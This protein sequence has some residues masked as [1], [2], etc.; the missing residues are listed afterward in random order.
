M[1]ESEATHFG[2]KKLAL[3]NWRDPDVPRNFPGLTEEVWVRAIMGAQLIPAVPENVVRLFEVAR[4]SI[5]YGWLFY[6]LLTL[7]S[8]Q[9]HRVQETAVRERCKLAGIPLKQTRNGREV[10][11]SFKNL[12]DELGAHGIIPNDEM[13]PW[14]AVRNLRNWSSHPERQKIL[15]PGHAISAIDVTARQINQLFS[16]NPD[17]FSRLGLRV[18]RATGLGSPPRELPTVVG[19]DVGAENNGFHLV[20]MHGAQVVGAIKTLDPGEAR[21]WCI[22][23]GSKYVVVDAPCGWRLGEARNCRECEELL[24]TMGY[25]SYPTPRRDLA[26]SNPNYSWM[27]NGER[28]YTALQIDYPLFRGT[29]PEG[30]MCFETYP[31]VASCGLAGRK[32]KADNK[33][34]DRRDIIRAAGIDDRPLRNQDFIDAAICALVGY[35]IAIDYWCICGNSAEGFIVFPPVH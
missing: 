11:R 9:L 20:A 25:S 19:I 23:V 8:E 5:L 6:P 32:L 22:R 18:R 31:Y 33:A 4:G 35:S 15:L 34:R 7:A 10:D 24:S 14:Q 16:T 28:L 29:A 21:D 17:Y 13:E 12:I 3:Q 27:L 30:R 26:N 1:S 2:M